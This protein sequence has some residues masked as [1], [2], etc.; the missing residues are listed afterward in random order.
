MRPICRD[1]DG[2]RSTQHPRPIMRNGATI[3]DGILDQGCIVFTSCIAKLP[4]CWPCVISPLCFRIELLGA[5]V[6][7]AA[8]ILLSIVKMSLAYYGHLLAFSLISKRSFCCPEA[9]GL[10]SKMSIGNGRSYMWRA[11]LPVF[12]S[13]T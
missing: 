1:K 9:R 7:H 12:R 3:L 10:V 2:G 8:A 5:L 13:I 4:L 6:A 11:S